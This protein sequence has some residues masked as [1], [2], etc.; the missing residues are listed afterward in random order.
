[1]ARAVHIEVTPDAGRYS[2]KLALIRFFSRRRVLKLAISDN[3]KNFRFIEIKV[4]LRKKDIK[5]EYIL[6]KF[7]SWGGFY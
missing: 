3:F 4:F 6:E 7:P 1:M 2:H 5:W